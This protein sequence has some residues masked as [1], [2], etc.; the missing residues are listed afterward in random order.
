MRWDGG[1]QGY[2]FVIATLMGKKRNV[3]FQGCCCEVF[4]VLSLK[5][6]LSETK[7]MCLQYGPG[8]ASISCV[9]LAE[10]L[11]ATLLLLPLLFV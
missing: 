9:S 2:G 3:L 5:R 7:P 11:S 6:A 1:T 10:V 8:S 4:Q